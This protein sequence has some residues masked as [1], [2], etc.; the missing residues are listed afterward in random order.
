MPDLSHKVT[1]KTPSQIKIMEEGGKKLA[2]IKEEL[3]NQIEVGVC[4]TDIEDL[5]TDLIKKGGGKPSFKMVPGYHWSTCINI[6]A[7]LVHGIPKSSVKINREDIVSVDVGFYY[8][9]FHTD[10]SFSKYLGK[11]KKR[12]KFLLVGKEALR[13]A[14]NK[15]YSGK[16]VYDLSKAMED[17]LKREKLTPIKALVGHGIGKNLHEEPQIPCFVQ[18]SRKES[19]KLAKGMTIAIE[20]MYTKGREAVELESDRWTITTSDGKISA[21][22]EETV[23]VTSKGP[24]VLTVTNKL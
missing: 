13:A 18:G 9:G 7:G 3:E 10:T 4:A 17:V 12:K 2:K 16:R 19:P 11:D 20:V 14:I 1:I 6:N 5:A 23:L 8:K 24:R 15:T 22:F 21:L